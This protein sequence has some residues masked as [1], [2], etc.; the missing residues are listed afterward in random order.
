LTA[1]FDFFFLEYFKAEHFRTERILAAASECWFGSHNG[2]IE[3]VVRAE[4]A[5]PLLK[6]ILSLVIL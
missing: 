5:L 2:S 3:I 4:G 1:F 6:P